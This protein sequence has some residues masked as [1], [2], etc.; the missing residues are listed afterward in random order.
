MGRVCLLI[1]F[2]ALHT[3]FQVDVACVVEEAVR[4][5][6]FQDVM[7]VALK[8]FIRFVSSI[9]S[10]GH[11][12]W[13]GVAGSRFWVG[14]FTDESLPVAVLRCTLLKDDGQFVATDSLLC[15]RNLKVKVI[16]V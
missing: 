10:V 12:D 9:L 2:V 1:V 4:V 7:T 16:T 15:R 8:L 14:H 13:A 6:E 3:R 11:E 5:V